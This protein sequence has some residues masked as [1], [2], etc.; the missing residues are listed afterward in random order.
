[1][2]KQ[3][4]R[5]LTMILT[6]AM[7]LSMTTIA[8]ADQSFEPGPI[9]LQVRAAEQVNGTYKVSYT[10]KLVMKEELAKV[11]TLYRDND[12]MYGLRFIC[13]L[14]DELVVQLN[15]VN[16]E[17]FRFDCAQWD[18]KDIFVYEEA[19][20]TDD[21][22]KI[23]YRLNEAVLADWFYEE[24]M[25]A[26]TDALMQPMTMW[27]TA[28]V[29]ERQLKRLDEPVVTTAKVE[30]EGSGIEKYFGQYSVIGAWGRTTWRLDDDFYVPGFGCCAPHE[31]PRNM[32]CPAGHFNDLNLQLWYHDGIHYC[33]EYGLM[34]GTGKYTFEPDLAITR[35]MVVTVLYRMEGEP[36]VSGAQVYE[37]V[38]LNRWYTDAVEWADGNGVVNGYGNG[39]FGPNDPITREQMAAVLYRYARYKGVDVSVGENTN[40]LSFKDAEDVSGYAVAAMQWACGVGMI[41]GSYGNLMPLANTT[42]AQAAAIFQRY[43]MNVI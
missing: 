11:A 39:K 42:R 9:D 36:A 20:V 29:P 8:L 33:V 22:L 35:G 6:V 26:V 17:D 23:F 43:C 25:E 19:T 4:M 37:D 31:C 16:E 27:A 5:V 1:M 15:D 18:G 24:D 30:L 41:Q 28:L 12:R 10:A 13:T 3:L 2:K 21:G 14:N 34:V 38:A 7:I 40:I 32:Y